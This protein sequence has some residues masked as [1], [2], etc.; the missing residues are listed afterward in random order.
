MNK[1]LKIIPK[2]QRERLSD[3]QKRTIE[4]Y[5]SPVKLRAVV[6]W[7]RR[8]ASAGIKV[9]ELAEHAE[10]VPF[11]ISEWLNFTHEPTEENFQAIESAIY[12]LEK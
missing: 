5:S 11:R 12:Q 10:K 1:N 9:K 6:A 4:S 2:L 8:M 7:K 3:K